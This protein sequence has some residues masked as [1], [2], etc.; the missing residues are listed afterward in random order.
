MCQEVA[1]RSHQTAKHQV[2]FACRINSWV[3]NIWR[4]SGTRET[5][6]EKSCKVLFFQVDKYD[7]CTKVGKNES[8]SSPIFSIFISQGMYTYSNLCT[9]THADLS[10][11]EILLSTG[12]FPLCRSLVAESIRS[13]GVDLTGQKRVPTARLD[14]KPETGRKSKPDENISQHR[15]LTDGPKQTQTQKEQRGHWRHWSIP[16]RSCPTTGLFH[17][18]PNILWRSL[19]A[20]D[21]DK[22]FVLLG[23]EGPTLRMLQKTQTI[24]DNC[25]KSTDWSTARSRKTESSFRSQC[26]IS[27]QKKVW[28]TWP[29]RWLWNPAF[30]A[31]HVVQG[32]KRI[33]WRKILRRRCLSTRLTS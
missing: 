9:R 21:S 13:D 10:I 26:G 24:C 14:Q 5:R 6:P 30:F 19:S 31:A 2:W 1:L 32:S 28:L 18:R 8:P 22:M 33:P 29:K 7:A 17:P 25:W 23:K 12:S 16:S 4:H 11:Q 3:H 20:K 27:R 15:S